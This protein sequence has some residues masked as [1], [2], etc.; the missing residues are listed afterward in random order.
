MLPSE[1]FN[2]LI[3]RY[4]SLSA[5]ESAIMDAYNILEICYGG[6]CS[7]K[8]LICGN[9]GSAAD[10]EH[11]TGELMKGFLLKRELP[12]EKAGLLNEA[13]SDHNFASALQGA[14]PAISLVSQVSLITAYSNDIA[15]DMAFAQQVYGYGKAGDVLI[16]L[17]TS[18]NSANVV[19]A[20]KAAKALGLKT[21]GMTG[22]DGGKMGSSGLC[23]AL[24][25]V[26]ENETF[27]VQ[28]LHLP[29]YH[30]IC[31]AL[32]AR[33]FGDSRMPD[34]FIAYSDVIVSGGGPAGICAALAAARKGASVTLI[35]KSGCLGG[36][37][38]SGLV[39]PIA[40]TRS[41]SGRDFGGI[42]RE[43]LK[44][45]AEVSKDICMA[46]SCAEFSPPSAKFVFLKALLDAK[47]NVLFHAWVTDVT[48]AGDKI[49][50]AG[51]QTKGGKRRVAGKV[52]IDC[53]GD[54]DI[55]EFAGIPY[56]I[57]SER[58]SMESLADNMLDYI[59]DTGGKRTEKYVKQL[60]P[61]SNMFIM[62][63]VD[64]EKALSFKKA[65][66]DNNREMTFS[67]FG[68][69]RDEFT[70]PPYSD[71]T[72]FE[73]EDGS[74]R[75]ALPQGRIL[76]FKT[77]RRGEVAVNM[78]RVIKIDGTDPLQLSAGE[79][80]S[81]LQAYA[82]VK[83]LRKYVKGFENAYLIETSTTVGVRETR[84]LRGKY[85]LTAGDAINCR[86]FDDAIA[87]GSYII[88]IHDPTGRNKAIGGRIKGECYQIPY[89][90]LICDRFANIIFA[91]RCIS[92]DH[93]AHSSSRVMGTCMLTGQAAG[94]AAA[95]AVAGG[96]NDVR[97]L[98][99]EEVRKCL[100]ADG[101]NIL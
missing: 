54:G 89:R 14:L 2:D 98:N 3:Q 51:I 36:M 97:S 62:G 74:D 25:N 38:T 65:L 1:F 31:A 9:G 4:P 85:M 11:I 15:P 90:A 67:D 30:A 60:Q 23:D 83:F 44:M 46:D 61:V 41:N 48:A 42:M 47:V 56:A 34:D 76:F 20:F 29:V 18:G 69:S 39:G 40:A 19:N 100:E 17:S 70:K 5:C 94:T 21:I 72:G 93:V 96:S 28:E 59:H 77:A 55:M 32:E 24:I 58:E 57:G 49:T 52:F 87:S 81:Q 95:M 37:A 82:I 27:K 84:R 101:M 88:D 7:G 63:N 99:P 16:G 64:Y 8:V 78:T 10:A 26:P 75:L 68:I 79:T 35:E 33:F 80:A 50:A 43:L 53:T 22:A 45:I 66:T 6:S 71:T 91:G 73:P 86:K 92:C 13:A 12:D